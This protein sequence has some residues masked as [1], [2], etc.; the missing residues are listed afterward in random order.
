M[1]L[2]AAPVIAAFSQNTSF[3]PRLWLPLWHKSFPQLTGL[4]TWLLGKRARL[5]EAVCGV[6]MAWRSVATSFS[7]LLIQE[8]K[9]EAATPL[10]AALAAT[11]CSATMRYLV[12]CTSCPRASALIQ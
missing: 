9:E 11:Q 10:G 4:P 12:R 5:Q 7:Q 1:P 8:T 6:L 3:L 2:G